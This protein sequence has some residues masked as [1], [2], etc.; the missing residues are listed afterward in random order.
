MNGVP[1]GKIA[2]ANLVFTLATLIAAV[3]PRLPAIP[4]RRTSSARCSVAPATRSIT[5][6]IAVRSNGGSTIGH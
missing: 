3:T 1:V 6:S 2:V 5:T 4:T